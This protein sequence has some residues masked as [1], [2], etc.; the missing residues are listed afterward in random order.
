VNR[1]YIVSIVTLTIV[2]IVFMTIFISSLI[3]SVNNRITQICFD[4]LT[5]ATKQLATD[6]HDKIVTDDMI[7]RSIA[8]V[9]ASKSDIDEARLCSIMKAYN[10]TPS[11]ISFLELL[12]PDNTFLYSDGTVRDMTGKL[13]FETEALRGDYVSN[14]VESAKN[15]AEKIIRNAMP[16]VRDGKTVYM[17]YGVVLLSNLVDK[18]KTDI[19]EGNAY[20]YIEDG[21]SGDFILDTWQKS[22]GNIRDFSKSKMMPGYNM[23]NAIDD[24]ERGI[25]GNLAFVSRTTSNVLYLHYE[26]IGINNWNAIVSVEQKYAFQK[27]RP[28]RKLLYLLAGG[29]GAALL[30]YM[31]GVLYSIYQ[32]YAQVWRMSIEDKTTGLQN[33]NAYERFIV[34]CRDRVFESVVCVYIDANGLHNINNKYGHAVGDQM[35]RIVAGTL[36]AEFTKKLVYRIGGDEFV[37]FTDSDSEDVCAEKMSNIAAKIEKHGYSISYGIACRRNEPG[38]ERVA[39]EADEIML[40]QK[41]KYYAENDRRHR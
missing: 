34:S 26:P 1:K 21:D 8:A 5:L 18:F 19:Y 30:L 4:D 20:A 32:A 11:Y 41:R 23:E 7:L 29:I 25:G 15:P 2:V 10:V 33:R 36:V 38:V 14:I 6:F 24:M 16:V 27:S 39:K 28:I 13:D 35:L 22:L 37:V 40:E 3:T 17:L 12:R 9:I 31:V